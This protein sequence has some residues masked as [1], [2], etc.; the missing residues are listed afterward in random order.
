MGVPG[1]SPPG[2]A[3]P[4]PGDG[5][6]GPQATGGFQGGRPP[7]LAGHP[8]ASPSEQ[9][10]EAVL[11]AAVQATAAL[12]VSQYQREYPAARPKEGRGRGLAGRIEAAA[13]ASPRLKRTVREFSS[14]YPAVRRLRVLAWRAM[15]KTRTR[16]H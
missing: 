6:T 4:R 16:G 5:G 8:S 14:R 13:A 1:G 10:A 12:V 9:P 3:G 11:D 2:P 7:G 15:E